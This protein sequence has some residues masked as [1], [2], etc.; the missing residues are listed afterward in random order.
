MAHLTGTLWE[1]NNITE[2]QRSGSLN[3]GFASFA[4]VAIAYA[5][6]GV[7]DIVYSEKKVLLDENY[8]SDIDY[9][10]KINTEDGAIEIKLINGQKN[11]SIPKDWVLRRA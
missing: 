4:G 7:T 11:I 8:I 1:K 5:L 2:L 3:H 10:L 9:T 6:A